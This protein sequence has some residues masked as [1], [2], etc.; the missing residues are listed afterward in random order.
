M[1]K[2]ISE[3]TLKFYSL[4]L[5]QWELSKKLNLTQHLSKSVLQLKILASSQ[6]RR[7]KIEL[8][9]TK[10]LELLLEHLLGSSLQNS[11]LQK[12]TRKSK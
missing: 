8:I 7:M 4:C 11:T 9:P 3:N 5:L 2:T 1:Q 12:I 10:K 6:V